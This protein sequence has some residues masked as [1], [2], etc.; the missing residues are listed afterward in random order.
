MGKSGAHSGVSGR[1]DCHRGQADVLFVMFKRA[2]TG[3]P[4]ESFAVGQSWWRFNVA[5]KSSSP[6]HFLIIDHRL[7]T[8]HLD[9]SGQMRTFVSTPQP[10]H[11]AIGVPAYLL[12]RLPT[13]YKFTHFRVSQWSK[14]LTSLRFRKRHIGAPIPECT[15]PEWSGANRDSGGAY[16]IITVDV[17]AIHMLV[18]VGPHIPISD[19]SYG[20]VLRKLR[21]QVNVVYRGTAPLRASHNRSHKTGQNALTVVLHEIMDSLTSSIG[22]GVETFLGTLGIVGA[23]SAEGRL[24]QRQL[25]S[26]QALHN[27]QFTRVCT[28]A[29]MISG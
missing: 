23:G 22:C 24:D 14:R 10:K 28:L 20:G 26:L 11:R 25:R 12:P 2:G 9:T 18:N 21:G 6:T 7:S 1:S 4:R 3:R 27:L 5:G 29:R 8:Y 15:L 16:G 17:A 19:H 13:P